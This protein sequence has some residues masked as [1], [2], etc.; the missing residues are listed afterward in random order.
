MRFTCW[1]A[2]LVLAGNSL[3]QAQSVKWRDGLLSLH[4]KPY[5]TYEITKVAGDKLYAYHALGEGETLFEAHFC[6][7]WTTEGG[8]SYRHY[9]FPAAQLELILPAKRKYRFK[10][11]LPQ[12]VEEGVLDEDANLD[13]EALRTFVAKYH[14]PLP[15]RFGSKQ[16]Q[17][18]VIGSNRRNSHRRKI[19]E[20]QTP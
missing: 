13:L 5:L 15:P 11:L 3:V 19:A 14:V 2:L 9:H 8:D 7:N 18:P 4:G 20:E 17:L 10:W 12:M 1:L 6:S 16:H